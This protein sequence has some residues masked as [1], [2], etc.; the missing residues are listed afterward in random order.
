MRAMTSAEVL[1]AFDPVDRDSLSPP[2]PLAGIAWEERDFLA[3]RD[4]S[5]HVAYVVVPL[6]ERDVGLVLK[7]GQTR[8]AGQCDLCFGIDREGGATLAL[9]ETWDNPRRKVGLHVCASLACSD[10]VRGRIWISS[11]GEV[12][13]PGKRIERLQRNLEAFAR[14]VAALPPPRITIEQPVAR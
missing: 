11:M 7:L 8:G 1:A 4:A 13:P 5:G 10:G 3:W 2:P 9:A 12:M 6:A 14:R